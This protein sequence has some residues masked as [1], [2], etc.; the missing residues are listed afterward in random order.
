M[1]WYQL[2]IA[3]E[4]TAPDAEPWQMTSK[5]FLDKHYTGFIDSNAY[6][7][8]ETSEGINFIQKEKYQELYATLPIDGQTV[9]I[10]RDI[11]PTQYCKTDENGDIMRGPDG[12]ALMM[13]PEEIKQKGYRTVDNSLAAFIGDRPI[14]FAS[15]EFGSTGVWVVKDFQRKGIGTFLLREFRKLNPKMG[16]L[17]QMT[18]AGIGL[19]QKWHKSLVDD[20]IKE[21]K[22][23]PENVRQEYPQQQHFYN[24]EKIV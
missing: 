21:N 24:G 13:T 5:Q 8:Y 4:K 1:N 17:G 7:D 11:T 19:T 10:R 22:D 20:A 15:N 6:K 3:E 2:K 23:V 14:G 18:N 9:E 16:P 12:M